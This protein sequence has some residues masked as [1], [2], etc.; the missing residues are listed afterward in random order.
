MIEKIFLIIFVLLSFV[1]LITSFIGVKKRAPI[2]PKL[3]ETA[4]VLFGLSSMLQ[5]RISGWFEGVM[6]AYSDPNKFPFGPPAHIT[7]NIIDDPDNAGIT[8]LRNFL[9]FD[10]SF[11]AYLAAIGL[12]AALTA[13]WLPSK[14]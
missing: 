8:A 7:Q 10:P 1:L 9:F 6:R 13:I 5:L 3:S 14:P 11:G 2:Y 12:L 4:S